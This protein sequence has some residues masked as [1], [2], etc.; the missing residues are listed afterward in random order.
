[1][2]GAKTRCKSFTIRTTLHLHAYGRA[3][4]YTNCIFTARCTQN[5]LPILLLHP[6]NFPPIQTVPTFPL[7]S[8]P[9]PFHP[10][11]K[12]KGAQDS[13]RPE[14]CVMETWP[15]K[16][17]VSKRLRFKIPSLLE[18]EWGDGET[19]KGLV[20]WELGIGECHQQNGISV[21]RW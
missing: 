4:T 5:Y 7:E 12:F 15:M 2:V 14:N 19:G 10:S 11:H 21:N 3:Y 20:A 18:T 16:Y 6:Q 8:L 17:N 9:I 13:L 1:M